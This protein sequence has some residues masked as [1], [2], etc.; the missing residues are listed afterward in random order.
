MRWKSECD[1][2][3]IL[4]RST[5]KSA[6]HSQLFIMCSAIE[7]PDVFASCPL[8]SLR[9]KIRAGRCCLIRKSKRLEVHAATATTIYTPIYYWTNRVGRQNNFTN[10]NKCSASLKNDS[11]SSR[12]ITSTN[13]RGDGPGQPPPPE[14]MHGKR[15]QY[16]YIYIY[17]YIKQD[18]MLNNPGGL[19]YHSTDWPNQ[20]VLIFSHLELLT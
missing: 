5:L 3:R 1:R 17:I 13:S 19:I 2:L 14:P 4:N 16:I 9:F 18:L 6:T 15:K 12:K 20:L 8:I 7:Y 10:R 11:H